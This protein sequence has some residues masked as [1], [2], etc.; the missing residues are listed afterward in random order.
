MICACVFGFVL[1]VVQESFFKSKE[2]EGYKTYGAWNAAVYN[3]NDAVEQF[4][5]DNSEIKAY[6]KLEMIGT[7]VNLKNEQGIGI[8][9]DTLISIGRITLEQGR[10]PEKDSEIAVER[11][12]LSFLGENVEIGDTVDLE[13][14]YNSDN[15]VVNENHSYVLTGIIEPWHQ[16]WLS[17]KQQLPAI[18]MASSDGLKQLCE[19]K[20]HYFFQY[21]EEYKEAET[22]ITSLLNGDMTYIYNSLSYTTDKTIMEDFF[23]KGTVPLFAI[24]LSMIVI[25]FALSNSSRN[26]RYTYIVLRS[27][28]AEVSWLM[29]F[30]MW[31]SAY[32]C[33]CAI[34]TGVVVGGF[35]SFA[36][37]YLLCRLLG[38]K[39][40]FVLNYKYLILEIIV[41]M[42]GLFIGNLYLLVSSL[43]LKATS[44]L[45]TDKGVFQKTRYPKTSGKRK[46]TVYNIVNRSDR[47]YIGQ[48]IVR[49]LFSVVIIVVMIISSINF[50]NARESYISMKKNVEDRYILD[51]YDI[52]NGLTSEE[53]EEIE[54]I[55]G[56]S[57][58]EVSHSLNA[59]QEPIL[60]Q[61][62]GWKNSEY[63]RLLQKYGGDS[64]LE[65][66]ESTENDCFELQSLSGA[67]EDN[68]KLFEWYQNALDEGELNKESFYAGEECVLFLMPFYLTRYGS[69]DTEL[70]IVPVQPQD[71]QN[72]LGKIYRYSEESGQIKV[73]DYVTV[74][75]MNHEKKIRVAGIVYREKDTW[76]TNIQDLVS[77]SGQI[78]VSDKFVS[79]LLEQDEERQYNH[80]EII[81]EEGVD[82]NVVDQNVEDAVD[83]LMQN[84]SDDDYNFSNVRESSE[85]IMSQY[86]QEMSWSVLLC[87]VLLLIYILIVYQTSLGKTENDRKRI[88]TL[89]SIGISQKRL[90]KIYSCKFLAE[91]LFIG[92][93]GVVISFII[94]LVQLK[95]DYGYATIGGLIETLVT[96]QASP[97]MLIIVY[98][99]TVAGFVLIYLLAVCIP[100]YELMNSKISLKEN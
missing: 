70:Y 86:L 33:L 36:I 43:S 94:Q 80:I 83:K 26:E 40:Y 92:G 67:K 23:E 89:R 19:P 56:I 8:M 91:G 46:L 63:I 68:E 27:M 93:L 45:T 17:G 57:N 54:E 15:G 99:V 9:D 6:G 64:F 1:T 18:L 62:E 30:M 12:V 78:A 79:S 41:L 25:F 60:I 7:A 48:T 90:K 51:I 29:T 82:Y 87:S 14:S 69:L 71:N 11:N 5:K 13:V 52:E 47:Y 16:N 98:G 22:Q 28:G 96:N 81:A 32:I 66:Q 20:T 37:N 65:N 75:Y 49:G 85:R 53:I 58:V 3:G 72:S 31:K 35:S 88:G 38:W 84:L 55:D 59:I 76:N 21:N 39:S 34:P 77:G 74:R 61:W 42:L 10:L 24:L 2:E 44:S 100:I 73:G 97:V 50:L 95:R 4:L